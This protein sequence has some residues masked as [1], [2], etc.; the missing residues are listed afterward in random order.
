MS[1]FRTR[2]VIYK[3]GVVPNGELFS[4]QLP[5]AA[6][7]LTVQLQRGQPVM[8]VLLNPEEKPIK[9]RQFLLVGTGHEHPS[10]VFQFSRYVG[11][12]QLD[13][14]SLVLHLFEL[15]PHK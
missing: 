4:L 6:T 13:E 12:F 5:P 10:A 2:M 11:T 1:D 14:G 3:Y 15:H 9:E 7:V 8:W